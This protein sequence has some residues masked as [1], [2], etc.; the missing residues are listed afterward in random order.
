MQTVVTI[1][2][3]TSIYGHDDKDYSIVNCVK[4]DHVSSSDS[5]S[6][7]LN[8]APIKLIYKWCQYKECHCTKS[9]I[10]AECQFISIP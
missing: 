7:D 2:V 5:V 6:A 10:V 1:T 9:I 8:F 3:A 4:N